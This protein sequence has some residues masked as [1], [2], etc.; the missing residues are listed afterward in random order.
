MEGDINSP[1]TITSSDFSCNGFTILQAEKS[2]KVKNVTFSNLNTLSYE[3]WNLTGAVNFYESDVIVE[4]S[5][6]FRN[7]CEDALNIIRSNFTVEKTHFDFIY[8]D[9]FDSDF[10]IGK[11]LN[12]TFT[13]IGN[14]AIDFSG[15]KILIN[16][17]VI[18]NASDKGI[19]G[20]ENSQLIVKNTDISNSNIGLAS[21]DLSTVDV[22]DSRV[23]GCNYG[24]VLLQKK[25]EYGPSTMILNNT[26]VENSKTR[27]LIEIGSIVVENNDTIM[28]RKEKVAELFY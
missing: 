26:I 21:K 18:D 11:V 8:S 12:T 2:S 17:V 4:N 3:G 10:S 28:G 24:V 25:P 1:I 7:Q 9:A 14:D 15:S 20:G 22:S 13:N 6:F 27:Y 16:N 23:T 19:S 5:T